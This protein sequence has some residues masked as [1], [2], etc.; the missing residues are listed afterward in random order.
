MLRTVGAA[1]LLVLVG[2]A[3][4]PRV[5]LADPAGPTDYQSEIVSVEPASPVIDL[6]IIGGDSFIEMTVEPGSD[7]IVIGYNSEPYLWFRP[8]GAVLENQNSPATY[9]NV[10]RTTSDLDA[11]PAGLDPEADP[12]WRQIASGHRW[13]WH[14]HRAHWMQESDP[15]GAAPGDQVLE[16]VIPL[17]VDGVDVDVTVVTRWQPGAS[18]VPAVIGGVAGLAWVGLTMMSRRRNRPTT[19]WL[20]PPA[21]LALTAGLWQ[22]LSLPAATGPLT[23]W[24]LLPAIAVTCAIGG[25]LA[26]FARARFWADA[27]VLA[28]GVELGVWGW[29]KRDGL[30]ASL[31][32]TGAPGWLD[33]FAVGVALAAGVGFV[34][35]ALWLLFLPREVR[36]GRGG[37][38][39]VL[40][41][42]TV[43]T[44]SPHPAHR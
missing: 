2:L 10:S 38:S 13:A 22:F 14:D 37:R 11:P 26:E 18:L 25:M 24:W 8:D 27:A 34:A 44:D 1:V 23:I 20:L 36:A 28:V 12:K 16:G 39:P 21:G 35:L 9:L 40:S 19:P 33:R 6:Q 4:S 31:I 3:V 5:A 17:V 30:S 15:V 43:A 32:P 41:E 29:L 42:P 7:V